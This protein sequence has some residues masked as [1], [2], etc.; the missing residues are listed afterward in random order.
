MDFLDPENLLRF[1]YKDCVLCDVERKGEEKRC[2]RC[3]GRLDQRDRLLREIWRERQRRTA[4]L[5]SLVCPGLGHFHAGRYAG[6]ALW[7]SLLPAALALAMHAWKGFTIGHVFLLAAAGL[8]WRL[9]WLDA[10]RGPLDPAA[11]CESACPAGIRVPDYIAL[12]REDRPLEALA[13]VDDRLPFSAFCGRA[14]PRPC[15]RECSRN[16]TGA[17]ISIMALKRYAA[18]RGHDAGV[19]PAPAGEEGESTLRAAVVGAGPAGL[20]AA[21]T[22]ARLGCRVTV[23]DSNAEPGGMMRYGAPEYRFPAEALRFDLD[24]IFARGVVFR[25]GVS[26]GRDV[27]FSALESEGFDAVLVATGTPAALAVPGSGTAEE[28]FLDARSFQEGVR[29]GR[30]VRPCGR[31]LVVGGGD[32]AVDAARTALRLGASEATIACLESR[33]GM[34]AQPREI[35]DALA[36]GVKLLP[37]TAVSRFLVSGGRVSGCEALRVAGIGRGPGGEIV[38]RTLPGTEFDI[39]AES[40]VMAVGSREDLGFLPPFSSKVAVDRQNHVYRLRLRDRDSSLKIYIFGD[41][42]SGPRTVVE[43]AASGRT[44]A[45]SVFS[46]LC[47]DDGRAAAYRDN[48]RRRREPHEPDRPGWRVR[49]EGARLSVEDRRGGF[50]EIDKGL[51]RACALEEAER[52]ARCNLTL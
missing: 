17:P 15:E 6:G 31:V 45:L 1:G 34:P 43:A 3:S 48:Y 23:F 11:P 24:R 40:V 25:G 7:A 44:A 26:I 51:S 49:R 27:P 50:G 21:D 30:P 52:C 39:P 35:E 38:P 9:A 18:D 46:G 12:V 20:A 14:C 41:C 5:L 28:G 10:R 22:L 47:P 2:E 33:E 32:V 36:E 13:L 8:V 29:R 42:A 19:L 16:E 4:G 37:S